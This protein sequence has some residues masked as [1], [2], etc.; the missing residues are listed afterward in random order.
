MLCHVV[1]ESREN[2]YKAVIQEL[3]EKEQSLKDEIQDK[4]A[5]NIRL[6]KQ[7]GKIYT[8]VIS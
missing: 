7:I 2:E 5:D 3:I 8:L 4:D 6:R 1:V